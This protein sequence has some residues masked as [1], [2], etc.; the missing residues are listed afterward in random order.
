MKSWL[1]LR[2]STPSPQHLLLLLISASLSSALSL[3]NHCQVV[4]QSRLVCIL[5]DLYRIEACIDYASPLS[6][7]GSEGRGADLASVPVANLFWTENVHDELTYS[8]AEHLGSIQFLNTSHK[9]VWQ[10]V[11]RP[12]GDMLLLPK[13]RTVSSTVERVRTQHCSPTSCAFF[14]IEEVQ[15]VCIFV[16]NQLTMYIWICFWILCY[17]NILDSKCQCL[18]QRNMTGFWL[19]SLA[20]WIN[21]EQRPRFPVHEHGPYPT[22]FALLSF[23]TAFF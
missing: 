12:L 18:P 1:P 9:A 11:C 8:P 5:H 16:S 15:I 2:K 4:S 14:S 6:G 21:L 23:H 13:S 20:L 3:G 7:G 19:R 17:V 10:F 22:W